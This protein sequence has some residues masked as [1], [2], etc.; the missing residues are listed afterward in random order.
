MP[1]ARLRYVAAMLIRSLVALSLTSVALLAG[2]GGDDPETAST[3]ATSAPVA[4]T[5]ATT[6]PQTATE[7]PDAKPASKSKGKKS[8]D[9]PAWV[10]D[11]NTRCQKYQEQTTKVLND[12]Q[13][14]GS[15]SPAAMSEAM[16]SII[17]LGRQMV[18]DLRTVD[19]PSDVS[20]RWNE[21]L[22]AVN[23]AFDLMPQIAKTAAGGTPDPKLMKKF[24]QIQEDTRP[25]SEEF[26]LNECLAS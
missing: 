9:K 2:C 13:K 25:F 1:A 8:K 6:G 18:D 23:G 16:N 26:G 21:F 12:F 14:S 24:A 11:V 20:K 15:T 19:V 4:S 7:V 5:P 22:D 3:P 10:N 17:P